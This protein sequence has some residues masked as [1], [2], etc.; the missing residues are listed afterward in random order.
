MRQS[1][2]RVIEIPTPRRFG[3]HT[4]PK[5]DQQNAIAR[6]ERQILLQYG[7]TAEMWEG[8]FVAEGAP[9]QECKAVALSWL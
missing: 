6:P 1:Y 5:T 9:C 3:I 2:V 4:N 8:R 7:S